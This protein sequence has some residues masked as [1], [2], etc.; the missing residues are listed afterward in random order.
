MPTFTCT[1]AGCDKVFVWKKDLNR[2]VRTVHENQKKHAC[3]NC[4]KTF[5][6]KT[7]KEMHLRTCSN[8]ATT[9]GEGIRKRKRY[10]T[11]SVV[12]KF[13]PILRKS[14]FRGC[15]ADWKIVFPRDY[16]A[17]DPVR[18]LSG[19]ALAM[20]DIISDVMREHTGRLKFTM[21]I[22]AVFEKATDPEIKT[23]PP[24]VLT[25]DPAAVYLS[26]KN[27]DRR[28]LN[29]SEELFELIEGYEGNGSGWVLDHFVRLDTNIA[30][31]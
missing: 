19:A 14:A 16:D 20:K 8:H 21:S 26:D 9:V 11:K 6:R 15:F 24:A 17:V 12:L 4:G 30:S 22:H 29:E 18:L 13:T 5:A 28:L 23:V 10:D 25:T 27:L 31:F 2:H 3:G 7:H 1:Y